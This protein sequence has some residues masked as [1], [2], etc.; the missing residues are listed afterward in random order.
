[1]A[2]RGNLMDGRAELL[3]SLFQTQTV[4]ALATLHK[5]RPAVSMVPFAVTPVSHALVIHVS[6]LATHTQDMALAPEIGLLIMAPHA[7]DIVPQALP[8][9]SIT[10]TARPCLPDDAE[11]ADA[12]GA[13][14]ARFPESEPMFGFADFSLFLIEPSSVRGVAGFGQAWSITR[15]QYLAFMTGPA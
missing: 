2:Q 1:M 9:I 12:R 7:A 8:R 11:Y 14:L 10:A 6:Q 15:T 4:G 13:Y 3:E 5:G